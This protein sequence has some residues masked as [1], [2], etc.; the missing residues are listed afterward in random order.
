MKSFNSDLGFSTSKLVSGNLTLDNV[1]TRI[2]VSG[3]VLS[4]NP[5]DMTYQG[6]PWS[7][8]VVADSGANI[9]AAVSARLA[10]GQAKSGMVNR[11][12]SDPFVQADVAAA[13][14]TLTP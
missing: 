1:K 4:L 11:A 10:R 13:T 14:R 2:K 8:L 9:R 3:G 12:P 7:G 6:T 5:L